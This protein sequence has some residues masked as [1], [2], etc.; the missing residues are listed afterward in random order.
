MKKRTSYSRREEKVNVLTHGMGLL[1][2]VLALVLLVRRAVLYG[3]ALHLFSAAVFG[4]AMILLYAASTLYH[5]TEEPRRRNRLQVFD[6][7]SIY[8]LIAGSYTPF[9][10]ISLQGTTGTVLFGVIWGLAVC[11]VILKLFFTGRFE[12]VLTL[13]YILLGWIIVVALKPL[14]ANLEL[15]G[16]ILLF[17]GGI[18]YT[19]GAVI[20][21]IKRIRGNHAIFHLFVLIGTLCH[22]LSVYFYVLPS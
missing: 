9:T 19:L 14:F 10:L 17:A 15:E 16:V 1:A 6:H 2:S 3:T 7:A 21:G 4:T 22:F 13:M 20:Y 8:I 12:V 18:S 5:G 11:G